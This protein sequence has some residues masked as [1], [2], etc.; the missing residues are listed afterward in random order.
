MKTAIA[1]ATARI[2]TLKVKMSEAFEMIPMDKKM[3]KILK[4]FDEIY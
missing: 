3:M 1:M 2:A 4:M